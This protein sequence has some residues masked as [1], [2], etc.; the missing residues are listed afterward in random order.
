MLAR[1][2]RLFGLFSTHSCGRC[3][4]RESADSTD[5]GRLFSPAR[6]RVHIGLRRRPTRVGAPGE[7]ELGGPADLNCSIAIFG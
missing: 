3:Q 2:R 4:K 1:R 6:S 5:G 7:C